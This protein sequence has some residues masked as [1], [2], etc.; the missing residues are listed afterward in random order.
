MPV[1]A[2]DSGDTGSIPGWGRSPG[3]GNSNPL[4]YSCL[5]NSM[6]TWTWWATVY[7]SQSVGHNGA[8]EHTHKINKQK[9]HLKLIWEAGRES[10]HTSTWCQLQTQKEETYL[11][12]SNR[13][14]FLLILYSSAGKRKNFSLPSHRPANIKLLHFRTPSLFCGLCL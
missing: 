2:R 4:Q 11:C 7:R 5:E 13:K 8:T 9:P 10:S 6:D 3:V 12:N 1:N 14:T